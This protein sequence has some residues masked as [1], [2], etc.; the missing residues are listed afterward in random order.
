MI[1]QQHIGH[2]TPIRLDQFLSSNS[3]SDITPLSG[4]TNLEFLSLSFN[5]I[6]DVSAL[7]GLTSLES[8]FL[9]SNS[10]SDITPLSGLTNLEFLSL[11]FNSIVDVSAL[12]GLTS[13]ESLFLSSN[14]ISDI[15]PLIANTGLGSEDWV[16][17]IDNPLSAISINTHIP[18]LESRGIDV[19]YFGGGGGTGSPD[20][21][22]E[23]PSVSASTLTAGQ[24]FTLQATVRNQGRSLFD[25]A[26]LH[27]YQ[28]DDAIISSSDTRIGSDAVGWLSTSE[29]SSKSNNVY[30]P[31]RAGTYYY[32]A[33]VAPVSGESNTDNNCSPGVRVTVS[34]GDGSITYID[35]PDA[36]LRAV[37][38]DSLGKASD[39]SISK[40]EMASLNRLK[41]PDKNI[42]DL[43]GL[44]FAINLTLLDLGERFSFFNSNE[45]SSLLPLSGL[46]SLE[47]LNL[48]SASMSDVSVLSG[49]T[50]LR[51]L[52]LNSAGISD[53]SVL[54]GLTNLETLWLF[55]NNISDVSALSGLTNLREL[56]LGDNRISDVSAL[57]GLTNL[58]TLDLN[59]NNISDVSVLSGLT[60]LERLY[61]S[62]IS[63]SDITS[64]S[65]FTSLTDLDLEGN[66]VSDISA[67]SGL[68]NLEWLNLDNTSISD[69]SVLSGLTNLEWLFLSSNSISDITPLSGLT[70][71]TWL[72]LG[73]NSISDLAP[74]VANMGL[75]SGDRVDVR[76]N[77]LS[78]TSINTHI[79]A[80][81]GRGVEVRFGASKPAVDKK[82]DMPRGMIERWRFKE[83]EIGG[84]IFR[85]RIEEGKDVISSK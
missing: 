69:V 67:L 17:L 15:T 57:S 29:S 39:A 79:P 4:L 74:L 2:H 11:S 76:N 14:S 83:W 10:I 73:S 64:L 70:S 77:P 26:T 7:S 51:E 55:V 38:A 59:S 28:S 22:V 30:A 50:N 18:A 41:A 47:R 44:E 12:S 75:D 52:Y 82:R 54:S 85:R 60:N 27:Y 42:R 16:T 56:G 45:I 68:T 58:E 65:G 49:L 20:L 19:S 3:I 36:N 66:R 21:I 5:S 23:S 61:L 32:G 24:I 80:L 72:D 37:I 35:I 13:L 33:C 53:V 71:L 25:T 48:N 34:G 62:S 46:T 8:L 1:Q 6:V 81:Q 63:I 43:T 31:S 78:A 9:S 40:I 84:D